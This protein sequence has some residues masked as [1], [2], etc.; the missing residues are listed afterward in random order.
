MNQQTISAPSRR[1]G[2]L[3]LWTLGLW[4]VAQFCLFYQYLHRE[5][6]WAFPGYWDQVR[7]LQESH[8]AFRTIVDEGLLR[9]FFHAVTA[10]TPNGNVLPTEAAILYLFLGGS[11]LPALLVE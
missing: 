9:G 3:P 7:Y 10:P 1:S 2:R 6:L 5:V 11:R 8:Q 4:F